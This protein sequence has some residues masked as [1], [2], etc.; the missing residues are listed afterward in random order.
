MNHFQAQGFE[1]IREVFTKN[2]VEAMRKEAD[3]LSKAEGSACVH[4]VAMMQKLVSEA[5]NLI[6]AS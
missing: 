3:R 1:I 4:H 6:E 2:E 5:A